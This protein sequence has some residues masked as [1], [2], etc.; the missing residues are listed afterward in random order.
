MAGNPFNEG[1]QSWPNMMPQAPWGNAWR[2]DS[3]IWRPSWGGPNNLNRGTH[4]T[5]VHKPYIPINA[6]AQARRR[7][8][9]VCSS[10]TEN[11]KT[12]VKV[13]SD[14]RNDQ[15]KVTSG[16]VE[17]YGSRVA[18]IL[19]GR[20]HGLYQ[21]QV[22]S[23]Y[24]KTWGEDLPDNWASSMVGSKWGLSMEKVGA[25]MLCSVSEEKRENHS[26]QH[27]TNDICGGL[28]NSKAT[29]TVAAATTHSQQRCAFLKP[30]RTH[31][32][33]QDPLRPK[34]EDYFDVRICFVPVG[35]T[36]FM[37]QEFGRRGQYEQME[38]EMAAFYE[39]TQNRQVVSEEE[40]ME[41]S[42]VALRQGRRGH[43]ARVLQSCKSSR[44]TKNPINLL[45]VDSG[46]LVVRH[47]TD[48]LQ[49]L[50]IRFGFLEEGA[51]KARLAE[52]KPLTDEGWGGE[53]EVWL[54]RRLLGRDLVSLVIAR[55]QGHMVLKLVDTSG[56]P[57]DDKDVAEEMV[58]EGFAKWES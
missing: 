17:V 24:R 7:M 31:G 41:G 37:V 38:D 13:A 47:S 1:F 48:D 52:V 2:E 55:E 51:A 42:L 8:P 9:E 45:L 32:I 25:H 21:M 43:R 22:E 30:P 6:Q 34:E 35:G 40:L 11:A 4:Q 44:P 36:T 53:A 49:W 39:E 29:V 19:R 58:A 54:R 23:Q 26:G 27:A 56:D 12:N 10:R 3:E 50:W 16:G 14:A 18:Q 33:C 5:A 15:R 28:V 20:V 57:E 46:R